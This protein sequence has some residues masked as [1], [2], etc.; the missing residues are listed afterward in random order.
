VTGGADFC[1]LCE[2]RL[3]GMHILFLQQR[4]GRHNAQSDGGTRLVM[5]AGR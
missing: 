3:Y 5:T 2:I 1:Q 4:A